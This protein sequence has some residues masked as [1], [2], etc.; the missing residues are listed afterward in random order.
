MVLRP[1][2]VNGPDWRAILGS[3]DSHPDHCRILTRG[4]DVVGTCL[5]RTELGGR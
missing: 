3:T 5:A 4:T 2:A 1:C